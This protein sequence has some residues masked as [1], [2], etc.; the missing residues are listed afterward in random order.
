[1]N[2]IMWPIDHIEPYKDNPRKIRQPAINTVATSIEQY[3][4]RQPIVIDKNGVIIVG[5][6]RWLAAKQLGLD[7]VPV[8]VA[9]GLTPEQVR[10][11]RIMDNRCHENTDWE[12][13]LLKFE[14]VELKA[15]G[16]DL[17]F[18]G[19]EPREIDEL[20]ANPE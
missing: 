8:H 11:Y 9:E 14:I 15:L 16:S 19:F 6:V 20:L 12:A 3:G 5:H 7:H 4:W 13:D 2:T 17:N 10:G 1:M 18:T